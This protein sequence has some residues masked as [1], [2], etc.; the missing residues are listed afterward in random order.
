M[1]DEQT[2]QAPPAAQEDKAADGSDNGSS[3]ESRVERIENVVS[4]L[5]DWI[6]GSDGRPSR[7]EAERDIKEE[8]RE[9]MEK[10]ERA[11][12]AKEKREAEAAQAQSIEDR[13]SALEHV[14]EDKPMEW[15]KSTNWLGW[16]KP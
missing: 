16:A 3:L 12:T 6:M 8:V 10:L 2:E 13:I 9:A 11:K 1:A 14:P 7:V 5:K 4:E 15:K